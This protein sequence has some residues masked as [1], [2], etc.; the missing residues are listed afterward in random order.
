MGSGATRAPDYTREGTREHGS[1][2]H[3][4]REDV[5]LNPSE[6]F[7]VRQHES[8]REG[9]RLFGIRCPGRLA[10]VPMPGVS[11]WGVPAS[12][13][14]RLPF[15]AKEGHEFAQDRSR[16]PRLLPRR[17]RWH[18]RWQF[19]RQRA[20]ISGRVNQT[21]RTLHIRTNLL[22]M[23]DASHIISLRPSPV[24]SHPM[25]LLSRVFWV[26]LPAGSPFLLRQLRR[27]PPIRQN[28]QCRF[29]CR[30]G[31]G[32]VDQPLPSGPLT[33]REGCSVA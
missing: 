19:G 6:P 30:F 14:L 3:P 26:R 16:L 4:E 25:A 24:G 22:T 17:S 11:P 12:S 7:S 2:V 10:R 9:V 18:S 21:R 31:T 5:S 27:F 28:P 29:A 13:R 1:S 8:P 23:R 32:P 15:K 33:A 20:S